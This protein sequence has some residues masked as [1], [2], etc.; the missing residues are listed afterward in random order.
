MSLRG[1]TTRW[2]PTSESR[3]DHHRRRGQAAELRDRGPEPGGRGIGQQRHGGPE[4]GRRYRLR[5]R[6]QN[7]GP[8]H[9][10]WDPAV[11]VRVRDLQPGGPGRERPGRHGHA[12]R[13]R[14]HQLVEQRRQ[15][16][17]QRGVCGGPHGRAPTRFRAAV[18]REGVQV[19][20]RTGHEAAN[21]GFHLYREEAGRR[22]DLRRS[23]WGTALFAGT[24]LNAGR[25]YSWWD[26][27][28]RLLPH[29]ERRTPNAE[30]TYWLEDI[31]LNGKL[32]RHGPITA[33][34]AEGPLPG[35]AH[36]ALLS[37][38]GLMKTQS[39]PGNHRS[40]G[41]NSQATV[42]QG[43]PVAF[44]SN[45]DLQRSKRFWPV[46]RPSR[47]RSGRKAGSGSAG[48]SCWRPV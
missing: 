38:L 22:F 44:P 46:P 36:S 42:R 21:L 15:L 32:T 4:R 34:I 30:R 13:L 26:D 29:A 39:P 27:A 16:D 11:L 20:W 18:Y 17:H 37:R 31:D 3:D 43:K 25:S 24:T 40:T 12:D 6:D 28:K 19:T 48:R 14:L 1:C 45:L 10:G 41:N 8:L 2:R 47:S 33:A 9:G 23:W 7:S 5:Q 35:K